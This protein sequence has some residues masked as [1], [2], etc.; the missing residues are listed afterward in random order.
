M[1][2]SMDLTEAIA[3]RPTPPST[4]AADARP[5]APPPNYW[6]IWQFVAI[7]ASIFHVV[8]TMVLLTAL[9]VRIG[10]IGGI[11]ADWFIV[12][13]ALLII[14]VRIL[15]RRLGAYR[16]E[17]E[18]TGIVRHGFP[19]YWCLHHAADVLAVQ[20]LSMPSPYEFA[21][22]NVPSMYQVNLML[23]DA[24]KPRCFLCQGPDDLTMMKLAQH[25][26][27]TLNVPLLDRVSK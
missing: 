16:W 2:P 9:G 15:Y 25:V 8:M 26:A 19:L 13:G 14:V 5:L 22:S 17:I 27:S 10:G 23:S 3:E 20:L 7:A 6:R 1:K 12:S 21:E 24:A 4:I 11:S 18:D